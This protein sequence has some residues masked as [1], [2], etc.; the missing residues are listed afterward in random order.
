MTDPSIISEVV[1]ASGLPV[2]KK[3][4]ESAAPTIR[5]GAGKLAKHL[6]DK[7]I[8]NLQIGFQSYLE[9]SYQRCKAVKT[10]LSQDRPLA[11]LEMYVHLILNC[12]NERISDD[13]LIENI[14]DLKH[15]VITGLAGSGKSVFM[16]YLT[17]CRFEQPRGTIPIFVELRQLNAITSKDILTYIH[18][19]CASANSDITYAQFEIALKAG[20]MLLILDGFDEIDFSHREQ[21]SRQI[22]DICIKYPNTPIVVSGRPDDNFASWQNFHIYKIQSL[23]KDQ[24]IELI[25][26]INYDAGLKNRF[27]KRGQASPLRFSYSSF[28]SSPLL[29]SIMLLTYEQ[30]AEIPNKMHI[31]YEQAFSALFRRHDAQKTQF[32]R[33]TYADLALD[34]FRN[35]FAAFCAFSY[36]D[37][38]FSFPDA[39]LTDLV[40]KALAYAELDCKEGDILRDLYEC[41]CMLQKDGLNTVFVHR[42]FQEYFSAVFVASY[43]GPQVRT[44]I[45]RFARR[46]R[47]QVIPMLYE[48]ARTKL[49]REWTVPH[50]EEIT[51]EFKEQIDVK[52]VC[53]FYR[54]HVDNAV[55]QIKSNG[56]RG[57]IVHAPMGKLTD[58][59]SFC[60][61]IWELYYPWVRPGASQQSLF[62]ILVTN[63]LE[64]SCTKVLRSQKIGTRHKVK[65]IL[66]CLKVEDYTD[67]KERPISFKIK[68]TPKFLEQIGIPDG[69]REVINML[70]DTQRMIQRRNSE[71]DSLLM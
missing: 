1:V 31:F 45:D 17:I 57:L 59:F 61:L 69:L 28:L 19:S 11:L 42:S 5:R 16:K 29:S 22:L 56:R 10:L 23:E 37:E 55:L 65:D 15:V 2:I 64:R 34:D 14:G 38:H 52:S 50:I 30:F 49:D 8:G 66:E 33:K 51:S 46:H 4:F 18:K 7:A 32:I 70:L 27:Q 9:T 41:V 53:A 26:K 20:G 48:M 25:D 3:V 6:V 44:I 13:A 40:K 43:H 71:Q 36:L 62:E 35:F 68:V 54:R 21:I 39:L 47:D 24:V 58:D 67:V 60:E 63:G 12:H